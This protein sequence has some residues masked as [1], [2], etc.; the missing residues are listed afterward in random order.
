MTTLE[1][2]EKLERVEMGMR[3][4]K[5]RDFLLF[6]CSTISI[7]FIHIDM[8]GFF[9]GNIKFSIFISLLIGSARVFSI[10]G[11][12]LSVYSYIIVSAIIWNCFSFLFFKYRQKRAIQQIQKQIGEEISEYFNSE[13]R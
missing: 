1:I 9:N 5:L 10:L 13:P 8:G 4:F 12:V 2:E 6:L 11:L 7:I 3:R